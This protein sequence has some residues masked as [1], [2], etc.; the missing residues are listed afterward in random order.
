[1]SDNANTTYNVGLGFL[2]RGAQM[3]RSAAREGADVD[4][5]VKHKA[6]IVLGHLPM[7]DGEKGAA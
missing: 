7:P 1:M 6:D 4:D 5:N 3:I 2:L